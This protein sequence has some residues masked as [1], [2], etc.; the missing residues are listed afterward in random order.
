RALLE[1]CLEGLRKE[2]QGLWS[3]VQE[4]CQTQMK[5]RP[6]K[7]SATSGLHKELQTEHQLLWE[8]SEILQEELKLL[9]DQLSQHQELLLKQ[10]A[11]GHQVQACSWKTLEHLQS[12]QKDKV[13][14]LEITRT[15]T[16]DA[17]GEEPSLLSSEVSLPDC[18]SSWELLKKLDR[19]LQNNTLSN[20]ESSSSQF[21][22]QGPLLS[23]PQDVPE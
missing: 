5:T 18:D 10:V 16:R 8:E 17:Q 14:T 3:Q 11:E 21:H 4:L 15:E 6:R 9:R 23:G 12:D 2:V 13:H 20:L 19:E 22:A 1:Q 7:F